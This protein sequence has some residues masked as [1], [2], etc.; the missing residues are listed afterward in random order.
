VAAGAHQLSAAWGEVPRLRFSVVDSSSV[1]HAAAPTL[2]FALRIDAPDG[3]PIR[4]VLL[5]VQLQVTAR[6][7]GYD[8][9][10]Q[11]QLLELFGAPERWATTLRTLPWTRLTVV[12]PPFDAS[13]VVALTVPCSYDLEVSASRYFAALHD[14]EVP[15]EFLFSGSVFYATPLGALQTARIAWD[16][17]VHYRMPV[18]VWRQALDAHFPGSAWLRLSRDRFEA[19]CAFKAQHAFTSWDAAI[20]ALLAREEAP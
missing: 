4:S 13:T 7:R 10:A 15:L 9:A 8:A 19:L 14:G 6:Q 18:A 17:E 2:E 5:D 20:D 11:R 1:R 3:T 12:V 16:H